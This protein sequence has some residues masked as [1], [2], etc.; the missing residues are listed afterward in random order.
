[1]K[2]LFSQRVKRLTFLAIG[3]MLTGA[4]WAQLST[5]S[6]VVDGD[7]RTFLQYLPTNFSPSEAT[8]LVLCSRWGWN[9][10][11]PAGHR[12]F[13]GQ[14]G[15]RP[16]CL[17][18]S[19][20]L[21]DANDDGST[22]WQVVQSG[23]LLTLP[24]PHSDIDFISALIE[25]MGAQNG[26]DLSRVYA[27]GY[28]NGGG[29]VYDLACRLNDQITGVGAVARTMYAESYANCATSHP[30]PVDHPGNKRL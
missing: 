24:N 16:L 11:L 5:E 12:R 21:P 13:E 2:F 30:T 29:F 15:Q 6:I 4:T 20:A 17:G 1:M 14:G 10:R 22:N 28:S 23:E 3:T 26:I 25:E 27:M 9:S 8:P 19:Q 7:T 18:V